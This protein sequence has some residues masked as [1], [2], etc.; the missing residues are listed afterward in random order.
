[1]KN[2]KNSQYG[3]MWINNGTTNKKIKKEEI[4]PEGWHKG[5]IN[6][7]TEEYKKILR[8]S[9]KNNNPEK[10]KETILKKYGTFLTAKRE[11][12]INEYYQKQHELKSSLSFDEKSFK[13]KRIH[14]LEEQN[15]SCL[16]CGIKEWNDEPITLELDHID[17]NTNNNSRENLRFL[18]PNCHSQT[19]TW[20]R[21]WKNKNGD[22]V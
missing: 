8:E 6:V 15:H 14:I 4:I 21:S 17:G 11:Q 18:C 10:R 7:H 9:S 22:M 12:A 2:K 5:R 3:T 19:D 16:H 20:R 13:Y 1:M